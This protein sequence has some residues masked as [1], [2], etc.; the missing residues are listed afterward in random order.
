M[1]D[2]QKLVTGNGKIF[3]K[4][5]LFTLPIALTIAILLWIVRLADTLF[6][7]P[8]EHLMPHTMPFPGLGILLTLLVI[9]L[10]GLAIH[11]RVLSFLFRWLETLFQKMPIFN[12]IYH[13][14]R[15]MIDFVS[16]GKDD[17]LDRVV[18][19]SINS[20]IKLIGFVTNSNAQLPLVNSEQTQPLIAVYVPLSYQM[21]GHLLYLPESRLQNLDMSTQEAMQLILTA[22][23]SKPAAPKNKS[24][25]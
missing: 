22:E 19:V 18:L 5:L 21:G 7:K 23:I 1:K 17:E 20:D 11:G 4:G 9:Y 14:I 2:S 6:L 13:N 25:A 12:V 3:I 16:G 15:E 8:L 10:I 24:R